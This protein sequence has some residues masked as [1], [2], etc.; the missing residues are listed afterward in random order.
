MNRRPSLAAI[1]LPLAMMLPAILQAAEPVALTSDGLLK[2]RPCWSPD[3]SQVAFTRHEED[4]I[5]VYVLDLQSRQEH[6]LTDSDDPEF[7]AVYSPDGESLLLAIDSVSPNQGNIDVACWHVADR[8]LEDVSDGVGGLS[9][10]EWPCWAPDGDRIAFTSTHEDNQEVYVADRDG[11]NPLRLTNDSAIDA[12]PCWSADGD[13]IA[14]ASN[15]WGDYEIALISATGEGLRRFTNSQGMDDYPAFS[16]DGRWLAWTTAREGSFDIAIADVESGLLRTIVGVDWGDGLSIENFPTWVDSDTLGFVSNRDGGFEIYTLNVGDDVLVMSE[17]S[18][19]TGGERGVSTACGDD[20]TSSTDDEPPVS[21]AEMREMVLEWETTI[22]ETTEAVQQNPEE[23][24]N[25][26]RRGDAQFF[27]GRFEE[28]LADY[29]QMIVLNPNLERSHWR[30][31]IAA[32]FSGEYELGAEQFGKYHSFDAVDREN[33]LWKFLCD[34]RASDIETARAQMLVYQEDDRASLP[35]VY[36]MYA[37]ELTPEEL[38]ESIHDGG[39]DD[40][41]LDRRLFYAELYVGFFYWVQDDVDQ[42]R[43]HLDACLRTTFGREAGYG[44]KY[45]WHV[46]RLGYEQMTEA[47]ED[48]TEQ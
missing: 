36:R 7:D 9:H 22:S 15:R 25:Y 6:R 33:G 27:L 47:A 8:R 35:D 34:A 46:A 5:F 45:M 18:P 28:A 26:S 48:A 39:F 29:D 4:N 2:Q 38:L 16:P 24:S 21:A 43:A 30:R 40:A 42:A 17:V 19:L 12:H 11:G 13:T 41:D 20:A 37:G 1:A 23:V 10:Q 31:G 32:W 14:F 3:G 44:P